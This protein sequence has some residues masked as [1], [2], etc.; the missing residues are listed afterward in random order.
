MS[1]DVNLYKGNHMSGLQ[2]RKKDFT[3]NLGSMFPQISDL[4]KRFEEC[5]KNNK[6]GDKWD[7]KANAYVTNNYDQFVFLK[8][9]RTPIIC[10]NLVQSI[11]EKNLLNEEVIKVTPKMEV[12]DGQ[13]RLLAAKE[14]NLSIYYRISNNITIDDIPRLQI[15]RPWT[16][17]DHLNA[18]VEKG[19]EEYKFIKYLGEK[20]GI[21]IS[22]L[23]AWCS[24]Y[25]DS[26][27]SWKK[28]T[29]RISYDH[30]ALELAIFHVTD[31]AK[32]IQKEDK[33]KSIKK[34]ALQAIWWIVTRND[35]NHED[36]K[37]RLN[38]WP[39]EVYESFKFAN[40]KNIVES[41]IENVFFKYRKEK[42]K[43]IDDFS[44]KFAE[45]SKT[46]KPVK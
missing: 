34:N 42:K 25:T 5:A 11:Q 35:Y 13:H 45:R 7:E 1:N 16:L 21:Q 19:N 14:L 38:L 8:T 18:N 6:N 30:E 32:T 15:S 23:I 31:F 36:F 29:Y 40:S 4:E 27:K 9:N 10:K 24:S 12:L 17:E 43:L 2:L 3:T 20:Y 33:I 28:G 44:D 26:N 37:K 39:D 46:L 41:L 22:Y